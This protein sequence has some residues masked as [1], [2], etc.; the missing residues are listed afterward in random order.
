MTPSA[1][2]EPPLAGENVFAKHF[3]G[4]TDPRIERRKEHL[5]I[6]ILGLTVCAAI[7]GA[8]GFVSTEEY[9]KSNKDWLER[10][11]KLPSG[12]P[13]HD[14]IGGVLARIDPEEFEEGLR[15]WTA[16][17]FEKTEG[18]V[19]AIDGKT[20]RRSYDSASKKAALHMVSAW[21]SEDHQQGNLTLGQVKTADKSNEITAIPELLELL[22]VSGC[23]VTIDAMGC[24]KDITEK[25]VEGGASGY[26]LGLK[27]N[28]GELRRDTEAIFEQVGESKGDFCKSVH[29]DHGRVEVRRCQV[30]EVAGKG[31]VDT[32]GWEGL[33]T[34]CRV[35]SER[36]LKGGDVQQE[37]RYFISSLG[38]DA[39]ELLEATRTHWHIENKLH[40]VLDVAFRE[41]ENRIRSGHAAENMAGV[42]RLATS[43]LENE[44]TSSV[45][46]KNKR[47]KAAWDEEYL[48]KVLRAIN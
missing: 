2:T 44:T 37:T 11:L 47:L 42:R 16:T 26:V 41:D 33:R 45:G 29:G 10:F 31:L 22:D 1:A 14:T 23:L 3:A 34:V 9:G 5:L 35:E 27:G 15:E 21:A 46:I 6:D 24:Q 12:I 28:Q 40:W 32:E 13:S 19:V 39:E 38:A 8:D 4:V 7:C 18:E 20:L 30:L 17:I 48:L 25:I 43:L 36:H